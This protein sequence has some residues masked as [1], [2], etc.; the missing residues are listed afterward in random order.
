M[1]NLPE[2]HATIA[3]T[4]H[5][6]DPQGL[7]Q[8]RPLLIIPRQTSQPDEDHG[9]LG[10]DFHCAPDIRPRYLENGQRWRCGSWWWRCPVQRRVVNVDAVLP[11]QPTDGIGEAHVLGLHQELHRTVADKAA[12][13]VAVPRLGD[14]RRPD[15]EVSVRL[16]I[17]EGAQG[18]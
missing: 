4:A 15:D 2:H 9:A 5:A 12:V 7:L 14:A 11:A 10:G 13:G 3:P 16:V 18:L 8:P 1:V 6:V 17:V